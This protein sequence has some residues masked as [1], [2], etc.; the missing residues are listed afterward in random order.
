MARG[1]FLSGDVNQRVL[2][3]NN[4][5][6][7][8]PGFKT[9]L[10]LLKIRVGI[11]AAAAGQRPTRV[12][13]LSGHHHVIGFVV[14]VRWLIEFEGRQLVRIEFRRFGVRFEGGLYRLR[15]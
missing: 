1:V 10:I 14:V 8:L 15:V 5:R 2:E 4:V 12:A 7:R 9:G 6:N 13:Q 3:R 11:E